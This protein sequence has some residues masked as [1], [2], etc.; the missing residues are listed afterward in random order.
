MP[1]NIVLDSREQKLVELFLSDKFKEYQK[2]ELSKKEPNEVKSESKQLDIGD[3][4]IFHNNELKMIIERKTF[5]DLEASF[6]DGR[7]DEQKS[8]LLAFKESN[9]SVS[10]LYL[11]EGKI[12][13]YKYSQVVGSILSMQLKY[14]FKIFVAKDVDD[15]FNFL[16]EL[17]K[18]IHSLSHHHQ[19]PKTEQNYFGGI[20][21][22]KSD[23]YTPELWFLTI[24]SSI[25]RVSKQIAEK[26]VEQY[27]TPLLLT[28]ELKA[29]GINNLKNYKVNDRRIG[30]KLASK[31][32]EYFLQ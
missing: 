5:Q 9:P 8:R 23:N 22:K 7:Y 32:Q 12:D 19:Q 4:Q 3:I 1:V 28:E 14:D 29:N 30:D 18:K 13:K 15:S 10:I 11:L 17:G 26:I 2:K 6:N 31:I 24:L 20:K 16:L 25:P 21:I 27:K